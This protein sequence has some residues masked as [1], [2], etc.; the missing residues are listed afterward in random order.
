MKTRPTTIYL[1]KGGNGRFEEGR[2]SEAGIK[3]GYLIRLFS[4][5][6]KVKVERH[7]TAG[8]FSEKAIVVEDRMQGRTIADAYAD[9]DGVFY[10][11]AQPGDVVFVRLAAGE[12]IEVNERLSSNGDGAFRA[13]V[14]TTDAALLVALEDVDN[15]DSTS[16][17]VF[18]RA[19]VL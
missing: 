7:K 12:H 9:E 6:G 19:R 16:V 14:S 2:A 13:H 5:G 11:I 15:D 17:E 1:L 10:I 4:E 8:G 18:I 3:P